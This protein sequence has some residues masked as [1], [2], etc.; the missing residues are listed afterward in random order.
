[1]KVKDIEFFFKDGIWYA[2]I[3]KKKFA[4]ERIFDYKAVVKILECNFSDVN[5]VLGKD[6]DY[7]NVVLSA[8]E[9]DSEY[10][11][12]LALRWLENESIDLDEDI[13]AILKNK[14]DHGWFNQHNRHV[15]LRL[16]KKMKL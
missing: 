4:L 14:L 10:W 8:L 1:M 9:F 3:S 5:N 7:K 16:L 13:C 12:A 6:F 2:L 11:D 15:A